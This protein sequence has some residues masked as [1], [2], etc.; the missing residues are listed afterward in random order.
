MR[1][2]FKQY[3]VVV[4]FMFI[5]WLTCLMLLFKSGDFLY[6]AL[7][8][9]VLLAICPLFFIKKALETVRRKKI[10]WSIFWVLLWLFFFPNAV[11]LVTD[12][13]HLTSE[14][15]MWMAD[16]EPYSPEAG[17]VYSDDILV[18]IKLF[19]IGLGFFFSMLVGL[20]SFYNFEQIIRKKYSTIICFIAI[21]AVA[22]LTGIGVYI[23]RFLRFNSWDILFDPLQLVRQV[24][25]FDGFAL[26]FI[27][28][29]TLFVFGSYLLYRGFKKQNF[30]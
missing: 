14:K 15:F 20:E 19:V 24:I 3:K 21:S 18:W 26:Q 17:L 27:I 23:G 16:V 8:W 30:S 10:G 25:K 5:Y 28:V 4:G 29:F 13:I 22:L 2:F 7:S 9:N 6:A 1:I 11:Y 12:F